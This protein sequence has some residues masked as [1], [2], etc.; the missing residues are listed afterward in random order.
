MKEQ[1]TPTEDEIKIAE[2]TMTER[3][4]ANMSNLEREFKV[5]ES[6]GI[7]R[8][9]AIKAAETFKQY[10]D[11]GFAVDIKNHVVEC[12]EGFVFVDG[13]KLN[14]QEL[15]KRFLAILDNFY[16][17]SRLALSGEEET[18][19]IRS[20]GDRVKNETILATAINDIFGESSPE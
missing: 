9:T 7:D 19:R 15:I 6:L 5:L 14:D 2:G 11:S 8:D 1:Y 16:V 13:V 12:R 18:S 17:I 3:Q 10:P 20:E 4:L